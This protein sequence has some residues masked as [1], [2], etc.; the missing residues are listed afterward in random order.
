MLGMAART[1]RQSRA[2][3]TAEH[4]I[5]ARGA[6]G[7]FKAAH[8]GCKPVHGRDVAVVALKRNVRVDFSQRGHG[9]PCLSQAAVLRAEKKT[10]HVGQ[11]HDVVVVHQERAHPA[12]GQHLRRHAA[13]AA[14]TL[15]AESIAGVVM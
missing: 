7:G 13:H 12:A 6:A 9:R 2:H 5:H 15:A 1:A 8:E 11:L 4:Q 10:V 3:H 14:D